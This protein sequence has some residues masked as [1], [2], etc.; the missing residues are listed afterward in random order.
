VLTLT[1]YNS[2]H[3]ATICFGTTSYGS[4]QESLAAFLKALR[5][6]HFEQKAEKISKSGQT[7]ETTDWFSPLDCGGAVNLEDDF[8]PFIGKKLRRVSPGLYESS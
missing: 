1:V 3:R 6:G 2:T 7:H 8:R 5:V 4:P